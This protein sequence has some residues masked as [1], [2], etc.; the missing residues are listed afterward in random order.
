MGARRP[1]LWVYNIKF[2]SVVL[3]SRA[4]FKI[5]HATEDY[6]SPPEKWSVTPKDL[7]G[8]VRKILPFV[9]AVVAVS[10]GVAEA[11]RTYGE[12]SRPIIVI[13]NGCDFEFWQSRDASRFIPPPSGKAVAF[14]QGGINNRLDFQ[15]L[16]K[17]VAGLPD[18]EFSFCGRLVDGLLEWNRL[19]E[20]ENVCY[21]GEL[22]P[23]NVADLSRQA[24][25]GLIPYKQDGLI[26]RSLPLKAY[27]YLACGLPVV[28]VPI[29]ELEKH[30]SLFTVATT[31]EEFI[32]EIKRLA[33]SRDDVATVSHRLSLA[34]SQS[35]DQ[36]F[37]DLCAKIGQ[38]IA[39]RR[40]RHPG[41]LNALMLYDD[42]STHVGTLKEHLEAFAKYSMHNF[43]FLPATGRVNG[44]D[45]VATLPSLEIF[46]VVVVHYSVR[47]SIKEHISKGISN[48]LSTFTGPKVLFIQDEYDTPDIARTWIEKLGID[49]VYTCVPLQRI[50]HVY[51]QARFHRID[52]MPTLTGY[53]PEDPRLDEFALPMAE[54]ALRIGYRGRALPHQYGR[55][56]YEKYLIGIEMKRL[57]IEA[58]VEA[59]IEV[60]D[61]KRIYGSAWYKF[62]GS[63]RAT[64]GTESGSNVFDDDGA[65]ARLSTENKHLPY[66]EFERRFLLGREGPIRMN[67]IS[68]KIYEA[69][70]LR[71]ALVLFEGEYSGVV[72]P[73]V[74]FIPLKKDFSNASEVF[75]KLEN[76]AYLEQ[77][78]ARAHEQIIGRHEY[79]YKAFVQGVD[80]YLT[81]RCP[82]G[83]H[84]ELLARPCFVRYRGASNFSRTED[85]GPL[86]TSG[87]CAR[88]ETARGE[89]AILLT[90]HNLTSLGRSV[91]RKVRRVL[92]QSYLSSCSPGHVEVKSRGRRVVRGVWRML[93]QVLRYAIVRRLGI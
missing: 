50:D 56:G 86:L 71:T 79:S 74:H 40:A 83:A 63:C 2:Y 12:C 59:D 89:F 38:L 53:I 62:L 30:P 25:I 52:F 5:F 28:T 54:R 69:I 88:R 51:P 44:I 20:A 70:R 72:K 61:N 91:I 93:P 35:Y 57:A 29:L 23:E 7:S 41:P 15:L 47:L 76:I 55:L 58:N 21:H 17:I 18:W 84:V 87:I 80:R 6:V 73:E 37:D 36:N 1:L 27:E 45:D 82:S 43:Y 49:A 46:D 64:L 10:D 81:K 26:R 16:T 75:A 22:D 24:R 4:P 13:P 19:L 60:D 32:R 3:R 67:Q 34:R 11:Y 31:A 90:S 8:E 68:P 77:L 42:Q 66:T 39:S 9:D 92:P 65:I 33:P 14:F 85:F 78:T 48:L